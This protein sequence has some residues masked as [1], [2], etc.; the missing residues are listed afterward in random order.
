MNKSQ[1]GADHPGIHM[2]FLSPHDPTDVRAFSGTAFHAYRALEA[3]SGQ[4]VTRLSSA[5]EALDMG[6]DIVVGLTA[7]R[8][9]AEPGG[10]GAVPYLHVTD[11]T[12]GLLRE[13]YSGPV[14]PP[15]QETEALIAR[16]AAFTVYSSEAVTT[17]AL[18]E[19]SLAPSRVAT[20]PFGLNLM[21]STPPVTRSGPHPKLLFVGLDWARK[22]GPL[23]VGIFAGLCRRGFAPELTL[24]GQAPWSLGLRRGI[25]R[26]GFLDKRRPGDSRRL[27][28]LFAEADMLVL[29]S[30]A[31]CTPMV[32]AEALAHGTPVLASAVGGI[33]GM[34]GL[35]GRAIGPNVPADDWVNAAEAMLE[36]ETHAYLQDAALE[37]AK[38]YHWTAWAE[39]IHQLARRAVGQARGDLAA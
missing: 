18:T 22:G 17:R 8:L 34:I 37:Q 32:V 33:P 23:A 3:H 9:L 25:R 16:G 26:I 1:S 2:G 35:A 29:P 12:P 5:Q 11:A 36:P 21:P 27:S 6:V 19:L 30:R 20:V 15:H 39:S 31:D 13:G 10:T 24:V 14:A 4:T 7:T 38:R 28:H